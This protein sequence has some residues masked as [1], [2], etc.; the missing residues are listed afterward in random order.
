MVKAK[1][2]LVGSKGCGKTSLIL[3]LLD[4]YD[5]KMRIPPTQ[6]MTSHGPY[7]D[8]PG[9]YCDNPSCYPILSVCSQQA[10][11]VVL[12]MGADESS[13]P[14]PEGFAQLFI[15][16]VLGV[17][18]K[19]DAANANCARAELFLQ[20]AGVRAPIHSVSARTGEGI[21]FFRQFLNGRVNK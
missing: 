1:Y 11:F 10:Q 7:I 18:T 12:V 9:N 16:P 17:I 2:L 4:Q 20:R 15:R 21:V 3:A 8:L 5:Q 6:G 13:R 19:K 14:M